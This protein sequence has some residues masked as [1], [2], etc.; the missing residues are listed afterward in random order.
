MRLLDNAHHQH[1]PQKLVH[2]SGVCWYPASTSA[3][4]C[5]RCASKKLISKSVS[6][7]HKKVNNLV[8]YETFEKF[9]R[10]TIHSQRVTEYSRLCSETNVWIIVGIYWLPNILWCLPVQQLPVQQ[11]PVQQLLVQ[12]LSVPQ[13]P[14]Q[15]LPVLQLQV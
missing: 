7:G 15:Q 6:L 3:F 14:V 12:Q 1:Q 13:L 11:L 8:S 4:G 2:F 5:K 10:Q 9:H